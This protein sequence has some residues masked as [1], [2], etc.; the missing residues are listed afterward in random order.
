MEYGKPLAF[1]H[2]GLFHVV[3][4]ALMQHGSTLFGVV[5]SVVL[6]I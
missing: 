6:L 3:D 4:D 5:S 1:I 2:H